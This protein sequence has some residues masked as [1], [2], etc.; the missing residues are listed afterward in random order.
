MS[1]SVS[2]T[3]YHQVSLC[4]T[5]SRVSLSHV[6]PCVTMCQCVSLCITVCHHVSPCLKCRQAS[7]RVTV[8]ECDR[9]SPSVTV[10]HRMSPCVSVYHHVSP[11]VSVSHRVSPCVTMS[12]VSPPLSLYAGVGGRRSR[13]SEAVHHTLSSAE[14]AQSTP[15]RAAMQA[16][17][18]LPKGCPLAFPV[19]W[20]PALQ[21]GRGMANLGRNSLK[22]REQIAAEPGIRVLVGGGE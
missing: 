10:C 6:S 16:A 18:L 8:T 13:F 4:V 20:S 15:S 1:L 5:T 12:P 11:S 14:K 19:E 22:A 9:V 21:E 7:L 3:M 17:T 2:V